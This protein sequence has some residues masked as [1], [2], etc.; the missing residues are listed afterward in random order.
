M[1]EAKLRTM[2][3][4]GI[5]DSC[6]EVRVPTLSNKETP[7]D[8]LWNCVMNN[9]VIGHHCPQV[10]CLPAQSPTSQSSQSSQPYLPFYILTPGS[11]FKF[12]LQSHL[13]TKSSLV[14]PQQAGAEAL[15]SILLDHGPALLSPQHT[16]T[17]TICMA[18]ASGAYV[19]V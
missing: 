4:S 2:E 5:S 18:Q 8:A 9:Y 16:W 12:H 6:K 7:K 15:P 19:M 13:F 10:L 14:T 3:E 11:P 1:L 17:L